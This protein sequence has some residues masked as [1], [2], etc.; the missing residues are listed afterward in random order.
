MLISHTLPAD[1]AELVAAIQEH[2]AA[3]D[4][5]HMVEVLDVLVLDELVEPHTV[6]VLAEEF[7]AAEHTLL[8]ETYAVDTETFAVHAS[9]H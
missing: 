9:V 8:F 6:E 5:S 2:A 3:A 7:D 4:P 1:H